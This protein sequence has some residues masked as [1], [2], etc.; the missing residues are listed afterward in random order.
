MPAW[1]SNLWNIPGRAWAAMLAAAPATTWLT[2][3]AAAAWTAV[4]AGLV[5]LFNARLGTDQAFWIV[6]S[7]LFLVLV[8]V[9]AL[10][11]VGVSF[12]AGKDGVTA[13]LGDEPDA[14]A[15]VETRTTVTTAPA[16]PAAAPESDG[17]LPPGQRVNP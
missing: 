7:A 9:V 13:N 3:G 11:G 15:V 16:A 2:A 8:A 17:E 4:S 1:S 6:E 12:H 5:W 10:A 14:V